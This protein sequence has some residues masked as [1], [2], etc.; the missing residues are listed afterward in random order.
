M[1]YTKVNLLDMD[2][3]K[4]L[5]FFCKIGEK[6]FR[7]QQ[8][9]YWIYQEYCDDFNKMTNLSKILRTQLNQIAEIRAPIVQDQQIS[10]DGTK[11]W[12]MKV[13]NQYI[14]TVYIP[15][16]IRATL[17]ISSQA[18]CALGCSFC[19]TGQQGFY[20]NLK[21]SEIIGQIW[22]VN[23]LITCNN[24]YIKN[25]DIPITHVVFMGMG[26]PLL[27]LVNVVSSIKIILSNFG[28]GLS[29]RRV[30][31]ST[32]GI[33]PG[34]D[35]LKNM[36]DVSLA[37]S[38]HA[39]NDMIR[40]KIMPINQKYNMDCLFKAIHRYVD[41]KTINRKRV[42]IEYVLLNDINDKV[43]HAYELAK[44]LIKI[45]CKV[46]LILWNPILN[47]EHTCSTNEQVDVFQ[48]IL[49][50]YGI[51]TT[52]RK[53]RGVDI[54]AGCGQLVGQMNNCHNS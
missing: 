10:L 9:M 53:I 54:N 30:I 8:V 18:G 37:I 26:E 24:K 47:I 19:G 29:K 17:C 3:D 44:H 14:E 35:K 27:N 50:N 39:S 43:T 16:K 40:N 51:I 52:I 23:K 20:R 11:K 33:V 32:A 38:L 42:T 25:Y 46:N 45:P 49:L 13:G 4:L 41:Q 48:K 12:V 22:R 7:F 31:L 36:I 2:P 15:D 5:D 21:V 34:I 28:F 1:N 6:P